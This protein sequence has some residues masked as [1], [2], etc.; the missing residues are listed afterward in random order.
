MSPTTGYC[1]ECGEYIATEAQLF[2]HSERHQAG[3][4]NLIARHTV[5]G[6]TS[7]EGWP[8]GTTHDYTCPACVASGS[9]FLA[10]PR[11]ETYW[12]S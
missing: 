8:Y 5:N 1:V 12:S 6:K 9:S 11:S 10:S 4:G 7:D 3:T 2:E